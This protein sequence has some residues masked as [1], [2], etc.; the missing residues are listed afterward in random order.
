METK[1][2][3]FLSNHRVSS[4]TT[5]LNDG[6]PHASALHYSHENNPLTLYFSTENTSRKTQAL[7]DGKTVKAS[8]VIGFS[9]EEWITLQ[10]DGQVR[11]VTD[12]TELNAVQNVHYAKHPGSSKYKDD[13]TTIFLAF[14]PTWWRYTDYNTDP[15]TIL[16]SD[17]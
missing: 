3:D 8:V 6:T 2:L 12:S 7:L 17:K 14:T 16:S 4:L 1:I 9:E 11:A 5:L 10:M 15:I 13:P